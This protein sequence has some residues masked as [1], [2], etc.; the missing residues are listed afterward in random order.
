MGKFIESSKATK[1]VAATPDAR[2]TSALANDTT[3]TNIPSQNE[4]CKKDEPAK[5]S[6]SKPKNIYSAKLRRA[7]LHITLLLAC[8]AYLLAAFMAIS[9]GVFSIS[10]FVVP[11]L[12]HAR[13]QMDAHLDA[14]W[15]DDIL[16]DRLGKLISS[17]LERGGFMETHEECL[18]RGLQKADYHLVGLGFEYP[19]IRDEIMNWVM[20][21][22]ARLQYT[23]QAVVTNPTPQQAVLTYLSQA[24]YRSCQLV[25][26]AVSYV[27]QVHLVEQAVGYMK[28][29]TN[30]IFDRFF[31]TTSTRDSSASAK[32]APVSGALED[33]SRSI[34]Q[35]FEHSS[36]NRRLLTNMPFGFTLRC[37]P[38]QPCRLSFSS[39][40]NSPN[41][42]IVTK[43]A[44]AKTARKIEELR[45]FILKL[46][47]IQR[48]TLQLLSVLSYVGAVLMV[49]AIVS[50]E[51]RRSDLCTM[52][53]PS[54]EHKYTAVSLGLEAI[55]IIAA[56]MLSLVIPRLS[57]APWLIFG[58]SMS[59]LGNF[60]IVRFLIPSP[61]DEDAIKA[62]ETIGEL[63]FILRGL[64]IPSEKKKKTVPSNKDSEKGDD[65]TVRTTLVEK[66][67][68]SPRAPASPFKLYCRLASPATTVQEGMEAKRK[69]MLEEQVERLQ[70]AMGPDT[71]T[72]SDTEIDSNPEDHGFVDLATGVTPSVTE[73]SESDWALVDD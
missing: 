38:S 14:A 60:M 15:R 70:A 39:A 18:A 31:N 55:S 4:P 32:H 45:S 47:A 8:V 68:V 50:Y 1:A 24:K 7:H 23:P 56:G 21:E 20:E 35:P 13:V 22:C 6:T 25:K 29:K 73:E 42:R 53:K 43:E 65:A 59:L 30:W 71:D 69:A 36:S 33:H 28:Q 10:N 9:F 52:R 26:E 49:G 44:I 61:K 5:V 62:C 34:H 11:R 72:E 41:A 67:L 57:G 19:Y 54:A 2:A 63:Y 51:G 16:S 17:S 64:D 66:K 37:E 58:L 46:N 48:A 12:E 27:K 40:N 3:D